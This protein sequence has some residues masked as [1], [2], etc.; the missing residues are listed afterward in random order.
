MRKLALSLLLLA[1]LAAAPARAV[2]FDAPPDGTYS[3]G[4]EHSEHGQ[5]GTHVVTI[6]SDG[7][8]RHVKVERHIRVERLWVTV[9]REDTRTEEVWRDR[10]LVRFWRKTTSGD[11]TTELSVEERN[12]QLVFADSGKATGLPLGTFP[13]HPWNPNIVEQSVLM[14]TDDGQPV[15][16][17]TRLAGE[18]QVTVGGVAVKAERF[19]MTGGENRS[20]WFDSVGRLVRQEIHNADGSTITF[21]LQ[22]LPAARSS[23]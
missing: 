10:D 1:G 14:S 11:K 19:E 15:Q 5:L 22:H 3:Y 18:E 23:S 6:V 13:T 9:Y 21:T 2:T 7:D 4:I 16:V 17:T 20:L 8:E 12:G